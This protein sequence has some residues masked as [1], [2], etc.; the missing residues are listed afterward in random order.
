[1]INRIALL[2]VGMVTLGGCGNMADPIAAL[3]DPTART[4]DSLGLPYNPSSIS[5]SS[6]APYNGASGA[7]FGFSFNSGGV[8]YQAL[9]PAA[10][11][12]ANVD[13]SGVRIIHNVHLTSL[14]AG[15]GLVVTARAGDA[16]VAGGFLGNFTAGT[17]LY[18]TVY[19]DGVPICPYSFM[20]SAARAYLTPAATLANLAACSN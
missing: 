11:V 19:Y 18:F 17:P 1:M 9:A 3:G 6:W 15:T 7:N 8:L 12:I 2:L 14:V 20:T 10:G 4:T 16:V 13:T 5:L